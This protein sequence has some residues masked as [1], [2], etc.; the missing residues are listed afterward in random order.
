M[1]K[2]KIQQRLN[3]ILERRH[4]IE[5]TNNI[6]RAD[7]AHRR[8]AIAVTNSTAAALIKCYTADIAANEKKIEDQQNEYE[9]LGKEARELQNQIAEHS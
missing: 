5:A 1:D 8:G 3:E 6:L 7:S 4:Q 9:V 2:E